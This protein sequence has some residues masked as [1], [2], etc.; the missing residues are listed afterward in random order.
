MEDEGTNHCNHGDLGVERDVFYRPE[1]EAGGEREDTRRGESL[2][3]K[4]H[5]VGTHTRVLCMIL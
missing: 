1:A 4:V 2:K 5:A 3:T